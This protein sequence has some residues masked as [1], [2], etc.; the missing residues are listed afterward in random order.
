MSAGLEKKMKGP[1]FDSVGFLERLDEYKSKEWLNLRA[2]L[3]M[4]WG[5][6]SF[7]SMRARRK[8]RNKFLFDFYREI[9][10]RR[11][12]EEF[13]VLN[14]GSKKVRN[15]EPIRISEIL[16]QFLERVHHGK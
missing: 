15:K 14:S 3:S 7:R 2:C 13:R 8:R 16:P 10:R 4:H 12:R 6:S 5:V 9:D 1:E 11:K